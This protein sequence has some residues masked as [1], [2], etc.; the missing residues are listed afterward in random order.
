[1]ITDHSNQVQFY[2]MRL[3]SD[4]DI[5]A[6]LCLMRVGGREPAIEKPMSQM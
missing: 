2:E 1:M 6:F 4:E 3:C 5:A